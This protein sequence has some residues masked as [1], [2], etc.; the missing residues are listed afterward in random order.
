MVLS[1]LFPA[2]HRHRDWNMDF[3]TYKQLQHRLINADIVTGRNARDS[4]DCDVKL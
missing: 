2:D 3:F 1:A 4:R